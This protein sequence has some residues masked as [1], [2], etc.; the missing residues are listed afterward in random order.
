M[1]KLLK[2]I[3]NYSKSRISLDEIDIHNYVSTDN[4]LQNKLGKV[5]AEKMPTQSSNNVTRFDK[6]D[7]LIANIRP[8]LKKIWLAKYTGGSSSDVLT[9]KVNKEY[10]STFVYYSLFRDDFFEH[11]MNGSKGTKMP[12]GDK[13]QILD[14]PIPDFEIG[15]QKQ[16]AKILSDLDSKIAINNKINAALEAMAKTLY[17]YWFVQF[18]FPDKNG[19]PYKSS[20]GKMIFNEDLKREIPVGWKVEELGS[21]IKIFDSLRI[22]MSR[23]EREKVKGDIPYY[24]ATSIMGYVKDFIFNDE[25][26]LLAEDGSVMNEK[27]MPIVQFIWG[28]TWVNNH[29][30]VIQANN[31]LHNEFIYQ[32]VKMIPVVLIKTG[33]IQ[34][35]INQ[36]NL[37]K[38][39][40][41]APPFKLVNEFS[42]QAIKIRKQL[43]NNKKQNQKLS[44]LRDWLLPMLMNGQVRVGEK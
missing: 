11:M 38:Y 21:C 29:A 1:S 14:F 36:T 7:I 39:K 19:K 16:I 28:K 30:H 42:N 3:A 41:I 13:N 6:G 24:G 32:L 27:G 15:Y 25:Y 44:E 31:K 4:L 17:D 12:R 26:I 20:E 35:K 23:S 40:V 33:S 5:D 10:N 8:Y 43:I 18:D 37:N 2:T 34:M 22:P 9:F